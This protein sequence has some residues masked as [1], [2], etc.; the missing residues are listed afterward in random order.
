MIR[1]IF[2][3]N[4][5]TCDRVATVETLH[6]SHEN[7]RNVQFLLKG[8]TEC[9]HD[10]RVHYCPDCSRSFVPGAVKQLAMAT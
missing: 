10:H 9:R 2:H 3:V 5:E 4:C 7:L 6:L 1:T 8:W